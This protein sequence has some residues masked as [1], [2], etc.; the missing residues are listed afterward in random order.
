MNARML[1]GRALLVL[2]PALHRAGLLACR[3]GLHGWES[4]ASYSRRPREVRVCWRCLRVEE[5][6][7]GGPWR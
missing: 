2:G 1:A 4:S 6:E 5:R 3:L 7:Q